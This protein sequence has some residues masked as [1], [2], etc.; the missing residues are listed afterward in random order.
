M[1][2][3]KHSSVQSVRSERVKAL[4]DGKVHR[5]PPEK[6]MRGVRSDTTRVRPVKMH[7]E[8]GAPLKKLDQ[9]EITRS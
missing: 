8:L 2:E 3:R 7:V 5:L 4:V 1:L 6:L 9:F